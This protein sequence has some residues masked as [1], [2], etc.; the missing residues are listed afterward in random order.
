MSDR[1]IERV[2]ADLLAEADRLWERANRLT[3]AARELQHL[4]NRI[5]YLQTEALTA[6]R[7]AGWSTLEKVDLIDELTGRTK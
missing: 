7:Q 3:K 2:I 1:E 4:N 5:V 6:S